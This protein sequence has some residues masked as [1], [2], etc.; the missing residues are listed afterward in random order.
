MVSYGEG[1]CNDV[2]Q[3]GGTARHLVPGFCL[4][5]NLIIIIS[6]SSLLANRLGQLLV[7]NNFLSECL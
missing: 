1:V 7:A 3:D 2:Y 5:S 4:L 6:S